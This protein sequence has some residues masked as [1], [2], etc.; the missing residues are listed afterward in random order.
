MTQNTWTLGTYPWLPSDASQPGP[1]MRVI[2]DNDFSGDPDDLYQVVHHVL[3]PSV[4]VRGIIASHLAP[5]DPF[6]PGPDSAA[7]AVKRLHELF[8]V[9]GL[10][11]DRWIYQ[12]ADGALANRTSPCW[13][14][15]FTPGNSPPN[16]TYVSF[17]VTLQPAWP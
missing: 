13:G 9:M 11:A 14:W 1:R 8:D 12:G 5:G 15:P 17:P 4:E 6:D 10:D 3:S 16:T 2:I 7:N